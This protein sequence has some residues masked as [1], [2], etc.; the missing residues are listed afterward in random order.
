MGATPKIRP[1]FISATKRFIADLINPKEKESSQQTLVQ[2][3]K[4]PDEKFFKTITKGVKA[5]EDKKHNVYYIKYT[6]E[7]E[8]EE[9]KIKTPDGREIKIY[10]PKGLIKD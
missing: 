5:F 7:A 1:N 6:K 3:V 2:V 8:F 9:R 10:I 4:F